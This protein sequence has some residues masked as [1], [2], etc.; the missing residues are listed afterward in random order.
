MRLFHGVLWTTIV[1]FF[2]I[3]TDLRWK[4][5]RLIAGFFHGTVHF[6]A[7]I[8]LSWLSA[9]VVFSFADN[10]GDDLLYA[11]G[12][13]DPSYYTTYWTT[14]PFW[15]ATIFVF[16]GGWILGSFVMGLYLFL[17]LNVFNRHWNEAFSSLAIEDWKNFL[18]LKID[19]T[20]TLTIYPIGIAKVPRS[21][22]ERDRNL[23][24]VEGPALKI[25]PELIE[26]PIVIAGS[27]GQ[28]THG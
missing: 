2:A 23:Q 12:E 15:S 9:V 22:R 25:A 27:T 16:A 21:R 18:R 19:A 6:L 7:A 13:Y 24:A 1:F 20:G 14:I 5:S 8:F 4:T 17:M 3:F 10:Q 26:P 28:S 11:F